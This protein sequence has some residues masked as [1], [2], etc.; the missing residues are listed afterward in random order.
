V[1]IAGQSP[2]FRFPRRDHPL[3]ELLER[4]LARPDGNAAGPGRPPGEQGTELLGH[5]L[6]VS[7]E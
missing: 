5:G 3:G 4:M 7:D 1:D 6:G 2:S